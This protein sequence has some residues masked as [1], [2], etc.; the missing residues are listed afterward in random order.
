MCVFFFLQTN[1][2]ELYFMT[3]AHVCARASHNISR[4][5]KTN[6]CLGKKKTLT[7]AQ[8]HV[9]PVECYVRY[10]TKYICRRATETCVVANRRFF[11]SP[12]YFGYDR[13]L[14]YSNFTRQ[15]SFE[16]IFD[17]TVL[18]KKMNCSLH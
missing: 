7:Y 16:T 8:T 15:E 9:I 5:R 4:K 3:F 12:R 13:T 6:D 18:K 11:N 14:D 17:F 2:S 10:Y 1:H